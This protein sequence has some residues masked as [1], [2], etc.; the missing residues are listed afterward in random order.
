LFSLQATWIKNTLLRTLP[1]R[2]DVRKFS[3]NFVYTHPTI[4]KLSGFLVELCSEAAPGSDSA[5]ELAK[6]CEE[7]QKL[8]EKYSSN[9][10]SFSG[11]DLPKDEVILVTGTTGGLGCHVLEYLLRLPTVSKV[12]ALNRK[13]GQPALARHEASFI[14]RGLDITILESPK[15]VLLDADLPSEDLGLDTKTYDALKKELTCIMHIGKDKIIPTP[16]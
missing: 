4:E 13:N 3:S 11:T 7:M 15:L 10:P 9:L 16:F 14:E 6:K 5:V 2:I 12:Y 8:V 1:S